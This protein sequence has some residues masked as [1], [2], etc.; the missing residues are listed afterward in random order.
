M[1]RLYQAIDMNYSPRVRRALLAGI[2]VTGLSS[3]KLRSVSAGSFIGVGLVMASAPVPAPA[4]A[5][6]PIAAPL[7]PPAMP[8]MMAPSAAPPPTVAAVRLPRDEPRFQNC[9][10]PMSY[11]RPL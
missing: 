9:S 7:P 6:A 5:A 8:P 10:V 4:P 11:E 1:P 3:R 2:T